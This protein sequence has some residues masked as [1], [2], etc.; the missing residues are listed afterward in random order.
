MTI[1]TTSIEGIGLGPVSD[2]VTLPP[3]DGLLAQNAQATADFKAAVEQFQ[4]AMGNL[5][6]PVAEPPVAE[7]PVAES[8]VAKVPAEGAPHV[9]T[10][11]LPPLDSLLVQNIQATADFKVAVEKLQL[12]MASLPSSVSELP[13]AKA[14]VANASVSEV[15]VAESPVAKVPAEGAPHV[16]TAALPP[17]DSL[18]AQ[19]IQATAD[20]KVA[21][22]KLQL[23]MKDLPLPKVTVPEETGDGVDV[24]VPQA[25]PVVEVALPVRTERVETVGGAGAVR[26]V[27]DVRAVEAVG[28]KELIGIAEAVADRV[29]VSPGLMLGDGEVRVLLKPDVLLGTEIRVVSKNG[30]VNVNFIPTTPEVAALLER[31]QPMLVQHLATHVPSVRFGVSV[32]WSVRNRENV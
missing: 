1:P 8:P 10:A 32:G 16:D 24:A 7:A 4:L 12:A 26:G 18:L 28:S 31:N 5:P 23:A 2:T 15:P 22:E 20:F 29:L 11:T 6:S 9:D 3:L 13:V 30:A 14:T 19:N 25:L 27:E 17:L 21:V